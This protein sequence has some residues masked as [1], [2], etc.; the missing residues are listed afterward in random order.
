MGQK[1]GGRG[2]DEPEGVGRGRREPVT[3]MWKGKMQLFRSEAGN[4][5]ER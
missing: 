1:K 3:A 4:P 5:L 2:F